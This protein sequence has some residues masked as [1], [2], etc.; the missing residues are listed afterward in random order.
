MMEAST[1]FA[2]TLVGVKISD[3]NENSRR[4][5]HGGG[6]ISG[7][8]HHGRDGFGRH[9]TLFIENG[10]GS[11]ERV[12]FC[13]GFGAGVQGMAILVVLLVVVD[14]LHVDICG[15]GMEW[16]CWGWLE[17]WLEVMVEE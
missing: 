12:D 9:P 3:T 10:Y 4:L 11:M 16:C 5:H 7:C 8:L 14:I 6:K 17:W 15:G 2:T 13:E 1:S